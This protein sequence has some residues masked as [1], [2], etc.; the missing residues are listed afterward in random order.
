[1]VINNSFYGGRRGASFVIVKNYLDIP[2]MT[3][4]FAQ[5]NSFKDV[6]F[7][8]YVLINNP[9]K[10]HPDNGKIFR[11]G[12]DYSSNRKIEATVLVDSENHR[13]QSVTE[14]QYKNL[15]NGAKFFKDSEWEAHGAEYIGT[16]I[17][18]AGKAPLLTVG[19]YDEVKDLAQSTFKERR[20]KGHYSP[21]E[22]TQR[23]QQE[24]EDAD[25]W[26]TGPELDNNTISL[27][28]GKYV[29]N[30]K[31]QYNDSIEWC[32]VSI[33]NNNYGDDT[34]AF[35]GFKFP[36][37]VTQMQTQ[38]VEPY[39]K[40]GNIDDASKIQRVDDGT[41]PY[42]N[43]WHLNIPKGVKGDTFKNLK[44]T[45][46]SNWLSSLGNSGQRVMYNVDSSVYSPAAAD[47]NRQI[48][49]YEDWNYDNKQE[50]QVTYYYLGNYNQIT[51][52]TLANGILT[53][54]FTYEDN[55]TF[56]LDYIKDIKIDNTGKVTLVHSVIDPLTNRE[57]ET[58]LI[59]KLKYIT[60]VTLDTGEWVE[61]EPSSEQTQEGQG[62]SG[63]E[64][65]TEP[66]YAWV[67]NEN[68]SGALSLTF[69][70]GET[71]TWYIPAV[72]R[73]NYDEESG[74]LSYSVL[75]P[76]EESQPLT[77]VKYIKN[78]KQDEKS[79]VIFII[80]NTKPTAQ[81]I[82][83]GRNGYGY[84]NLE[85]WIPDEEEELEQEEETAAERRNNILQ[86]IG[87]NEFDV[88]PIKAITSM[89]YDGNTVWANYTTGEPQKIIDNFYTIEEFNYDED[90]ATLSIRKS[91]ES[92]SE[93]HYY[94][95][96]FPKEISYNYDTDNLEYTVDAAGTQK[97]V[98]G[99]LPLIRDVSIG[100]NKNL[101]IQM[102]SEGIENQFIT[103]AAGATYD[104]NHRSEDGWVYIGNL[105]QPLQILKVA[106]VFT[107]PR[108]YDLFYE[109]QALQEKYS[110]LYNILNDITIY[111]TSKTKIAAAAL[112]A[113]YPDGI[114]TGLLGEE[115]NNGTLG[116]VTVDLEA[117]K[118][119]NG[120]IVYSDSKLFFAYDYSPVNNIPE[121]I[122]IFD[123]EGQQQTTINIDR[124]YGNWYSLGRIESPGSITVGPSS[125]LGEEGTM[126]TGEILLTTN[127]ICSISL[128]PQNSFSNKM[129]QIK[130]GSTYKTK[131]INTDGNVP[132]SSISVQMGGTEVS[133]EPSLVTYD[134]NMKTLTI[135][136]TGDVIITKS[137][138]N[139]D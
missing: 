32:C 81:E 58:V 126:K 53:F 139:S 93:T 51:N 41:H 138:D 65:P 132:L 122:T 92:E 50:G 1:M 97:K 26:R 33:R 37:L 35:I 135:K 84:F 44:V 123:D 128:I 14:E 95:L 48:L 49:I 114:V 77:A 83:D 113:L 38:Q 109:N 12:Y 23:I 70:D 7:D 75:G 46:Y 106:T 21:T 137:S 72:S 134:E 117:Y 130:L 45:T 107:F 91:N 28:P 56:T 108:F 98:V 63:E 11:R 29:E 96:N 85:F 116:L 60:D 124:L 52:V 125:K 102:N 101:Y 99:K 47:I 71:Q 67:P 43:K 119:N 87:E 80:Y 103:P 79:G 39:N 88:F 86:A 20:S 100:D 9:N 121:Q 82:A 24:Q 118:D 78:I 19:A 115:S 15:P 10:N 22:D 36:Y 27:I 17:G 40:N 120:D 69:N 6:S 64:E 90:N 16:I 62:G 55:K 112:N 111:T 131:I 42:Y 104:N 31:N 2:S 34:E 59:N 8:E 5:G 4:D 89:T 68:P 127:K 129:S 74:Q 25:T 105:A 13:Y 73:I 3:T 66:T 136:V 57:K 94:T 54:S 18:P 76:T 110:G 133:T 30:G 61:V